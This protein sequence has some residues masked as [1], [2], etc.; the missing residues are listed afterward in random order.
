MSEEEKKTPSKEEKEREEKGD[1]D[2][3]KTPPSPR[4]RTRRRLMEEMPNMPT[5]LINFGIMP[6]M[7]GNRPQIPNLPPHRQP[8]L[9]N[10]L[11]PQNPRLLNH[12]VNQLNPFSP[13]IFQ[14]LREREQ[15][16]RRNLTRASG[17]QPSF[18]SPQERN[19]SIPMNT[20]TQNQQNYLPRPSSRG[21]NEEED[22]DEEKSPKSKRQRKQ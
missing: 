5:D 17:N 8:H 10:L 6:F 13:N 2:E 16:Q 18:L 15:G 20:P 4:T 22:T 14:Q 1:P 9:P 21:F 12:P 11:Q 7:F 19:F 3:P